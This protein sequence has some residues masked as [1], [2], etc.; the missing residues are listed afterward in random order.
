MVFSYLV[1]FIDSGSAEIL[2]PSV[3]VKGY[4]S[5]DAEPLAQ[6]DVFGAEFFAKQLAQSAIFFLEL[7]EFGKS[8]V[9]SNWAGRRP[10]RQCSE[11]FF[12]YVIGLIGY[13]SRA[14]G[15]F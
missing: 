1:N 7:N 3:I 5:V 4:C 8:V 12:P 10:K 11:G 6:F 13:R 9:N 14:H 15:I 2:P